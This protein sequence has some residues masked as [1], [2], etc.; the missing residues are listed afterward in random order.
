ME[1]QRPW[2]QYYSEEAKTWSPRHTNMLTAFQAAVASGRGGIRYF[3]SFLSWSEIDNASDRLAVWAA[4]RGLRQ[5]HRLSIILQNVPSFAIATVA[6]WKLRAI[7][8]PGN[9]MYKPAELARIF[10]DSTPT[11]IICHDEHHGQV[12]SA[13][14]LAGLRSEVLTVSARDHALSPDPRVV[15]LA[16]STP[17]S[18]ALMPILTQGQSKPAPV[19]ANPEGLALLLYTSGTTGVPKGAMLQQAS[20]ASNAQ[21][22]GDWCAVHTDSRVLGIA[23]LFHITGF[24]CHLS[25]A[26]VERCELILHYRFE[27]SAV[28]DVIRR[29][30]PTYAIGAITAFNALACRPDA[31]PE[32]FACFEQ[33]HS[34]G[35]PI[36]PALRDTIRE[37]LGILIRNAYGMTETAAP[38][39]FTPLG[40][41]SPVDPHS[42]A[43][44]IGIPGYG[45]DAMIVDDAGCELPAGEI[46]ELC[47]KGRQI[48][49]GYWNKPEETRA[50]LANGWMHS[51]D[52]GF[53]DP[54]GWFYLVDRKKDVIIAS[55]FKVWPREVED[56]LYA[57]PAIREAA[58]VGAPDSYRGETVIAYVSL[59][60]E[61]QVDPT[62]LIEHCR[63]L[64]ASYKV[65]REIR[66]LDELPK[67][68]TGK[69]QR[70]IL[71]ERSA[72]ST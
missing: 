45:T 56:A 29:E 40:F 23:P 7:P 27:S 69:I 18:R 57:H 48:M 1:H 35:A 6:A 64:L 2:L 30:R 67:T 47:L 58:V 39:H 62:T 9:P 15:P 31:K 61:Q 60:S 51:G 43:L 28:L 3:G 13:L 50:A 53:M 55:G 65:P 36:A 12:E 22:A 44:S 19:Q 49:L 14:A 10:S 66:V 16:P 71:R 17:S 37:K 52:V 72:T 5:G 41:A 25:M 46:G 26:I 33:V 34:G 4:A 24:V 38:T 21:H 32:D 20:I 42:G 68:V 63:G 59:R 8:T 54:D 11:L 70:N